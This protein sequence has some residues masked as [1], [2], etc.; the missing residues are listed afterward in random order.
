MCPG[1]MQKFFAG[2]GGYK[3]GGGGVIHE[4]IFTGD[5]YIKGCPWVT[6]ILHL[7]PKTGVIHEG[8]IRRHYS[9]TIA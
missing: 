6:F 5:L 4:K 9:I 8:I 3:L 7:Q 1:V 2:D